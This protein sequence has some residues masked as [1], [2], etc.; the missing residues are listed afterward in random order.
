MLCPLLHCVIAPTLPSL[1]LRQAIARELLRAKGMT[2]GY[3]EHIGKA[4]DLGAGLAPIMLFPDC[5]PN[6]RKHHL[7]SWRGP[8]KLVYPAGWFGLIIDIKAR[9]ALLN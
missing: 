9:P 7:L 1:P 8:A 4:V 6:R 3:P 2:D 5:P